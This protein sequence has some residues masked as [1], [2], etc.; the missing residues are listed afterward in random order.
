[1]SSHSLFSI[2]TLSLGII[3]LKAPGAFAN[4]VDEDGILRT[5]DGKAAYGWYADAR[6]AC[7]RGTH[8]PTVREFAKW[9]QSRGAKGVLEVHAVSGTRAPDTY[10]KISAV[11]PNG[12]HDEFYFSS[13]GFRRAP[14]VGLDS[15]FWSSS[16]MRDEYRPGDGDA[17]FINGGSA[18]LDHCNPEHGVRGFALRILCFRNH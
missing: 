11:N 13:E 17:Y 16:I 12:K 1:M 14:G 8:L 9:A 4:Y 5:D 7:P 2:I 3:C 6:K 18:I 15:A 10:M